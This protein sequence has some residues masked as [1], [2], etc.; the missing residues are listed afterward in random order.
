MKSKR[1]NDKL[2]YQKL[3]NDYTWLK[4]KNKIIISPDVDGFLCGLLVSYYLGWEIVGFYD[5]SKLLVDKD[6]QNWRECV[7][8]DM[9]IYQKDVRSV[10]NHLLLY[11]KNKEP[12]TWRINFTQCIN[13]NNL[14]KFDRLH[15]FKRKYPFG[16][17]HFLICLLEN[18]GK[19]VKISKDAIGIILYAD[20]VFKSLMNY[21]ENCVD[22]LN[23]LSAKELEIF[24]HFRDAKLSNIIHSLE[25]IFRSLK[26]PKGKLQLKK[27]TSDI[28]DKMRN[29]LRQLS[30]LTGWEINEDNWKT[31]NL[32]KLQEPIKIERDR[33]EGISSKKYEK[34]LS[35]PNLISFSFPSYDRLEYSIYIPV[36]RRSRLPSRISSSR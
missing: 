19:E 25:E 9:E 13:P 29:F 24:K 27:N 8:L 33:K 16:T 31:L 32:D 23:W 5:G 28:Q 20:G 2:D 26:L 30:K 15:D 12:S 35:K 4:E 34:V 21:P 6:V 3:L 36:K 18:M 17:I 10:G 22:W 14:R 11:N 1:E 7:F